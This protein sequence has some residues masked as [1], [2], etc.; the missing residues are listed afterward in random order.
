MESASSEASSQAALVEQF[1]ARI[2]ELQGDLSSSKEKIEALEDEHAQSATSASEAAAIEHEALLASQAKLDLLSSEVENLKAVHA[3]TLQDSESR[4]AGLLEKLTLVETL[5]AQ[6]SSLKVEKEENAN[7]LS[8]LEVEILELKE[9]QDGLE[10]TRDIL[11]KQVASLEDE[12]AKAA[13][14]AA[15]AVEEGNN[16]DDSHA[17]EL[18]TM[19]KQHQDELEAGSSRYNELVASLEVLKS[20]LLVAETAKEKAER[21]CSLLEEAQ[22]IK[23]AELEQHHA[24]N[25]AALEVKIAKITEELQVRFIILLYC[26]NLT[27]F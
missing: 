2:N 23:M 20:D 6:V 26:L 11:Q 7:K 10:D 18:A 19:A 17:Q 5:E 27:R 1:K 24:T 12:V 8:E 13:V 25:V 22:A 15:M 16:K 4:I 3:K 9:A 14:S 21:E